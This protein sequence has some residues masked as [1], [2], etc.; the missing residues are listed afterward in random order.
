MAYVKAGI[1]LATFDD[2]QQRCARSGGFDV[3][4]RREVEA[5]QSTHGVDALRTH[6]NGPGLSSALREQ[7]RVASAQVVRQVSSSFALRAWRAR[8]CLTFR[9]PGVTLSSR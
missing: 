2:L 9:L 3:A 8:W 4:Q 7:V 1:V 5:W 6:L